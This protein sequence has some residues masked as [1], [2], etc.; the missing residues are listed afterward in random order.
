MKEKVLEEIHIFKRLIEES[1]LI[2]NINIEALHNISKKLKQFKIYLPL[3]G[4]FNAGKSSILN[5]LLG[6]DELLATDIIP[7]TAIATEILYDNNE[8]VEVYGFDSDEPIETFDNL[9]V[10]KNRDITN[11]GYLK[12]YKDLEFLKENSDMVLVDMPGL[13]S[14]IERHNKQIFN[15]IEK[16]AIS[17]IAIIDIQDGSIRNSTLRFIDELDSYQLDFF[18][19]LNKIDKVPSNEVEN[20]KDNIKSQL[21]KYSDNPFVGGVSSFDDDIDDFKTVLF[22]IDKDKYIKSIFIVQIISQVDKISKDLIVR[23][24]LLTINTEEI[25]KKLLE[26]QE[27]IYQLDKSLRKEKQA[28]EN[29]FSSNIKNQILQ[30]VK[31]ALLNSMD[32]LIASIETSQESFSSSVNEIIRPILINSIHNHTE[33]VFNIALDDLEQSSKDI[34]M[35]ISNIVD[36]SNTALQ[37]VGTTLIGIPS[38]AKILTFVSTKINPVITVLS[39]IINVVSMFFGNSKEDQEREK[40]NKLRDNIKNSA[41]P[42]IINKLDPTINNALRDISDNFFKELEAS[43]NAQKDELIESLNSAKN[44]KKEYLDDIKSQTKDFEDSIERLN[45]F[46]NK[47]R[48]YSATS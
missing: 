39:T 33:E 27:G 37:V 43:I 2:D 13:D 42:N 20:I 25:D 15:Y 30:D 46:K 38:L 41:I 10:L 32:E 23:K 21:L 17:F 18:V 26:F 28:I 40:Q 44:E 7:E 36:K 19:I 1:R 6:V 11:Y 16:E 48:S 29:K 9:E 45:G 31:N 3:I 22:T 34:F 35:D 24:N 4:N 8:R 5:T 12:V 47:L 14:N